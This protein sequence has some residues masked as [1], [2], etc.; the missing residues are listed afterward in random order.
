MKLTKIKTQIISFIIC[1]ATCIVI[2]PAADAARKNPLDFFKKEETVTA[3]VEATTE[4]TEETAKTEN[5]TETE[6]KE[7]KKAVYTQRDKIIDYAL[8]EVGYSQQNGY[9]KFSAEFGSGYMAWCNYFVVWC[10]KRAGV[11][12]QVITGTS[13]YDGNCLIY[14]NGLK[15]QGRFYA[16]DGRYT[17]KKGDLVFFNRSRSTSN[18]THIGFVLSADK[19]SVTTIEGNVNLNGRKSV[20]KITRPRN[21]YS[22][23]IIIIGFGVPAY[24]NEEVPKVTI[25]KQPDKVPV[26]SNSKRKKDLIDVKKFETNST[27]DERIKLTEAIRKAAETTD[28]ICKNIDFE[29]VVKISYYNNSELPCTSKI[30]MCKYS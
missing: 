29:S 8:S 14:M 10:A 4:K 23:S 2:F 6:K 27:V 30:C 19:D 17:P 12:P 16:D 9:N 26:K 11:S 22:G 7:T 20:V 13:S 5:K 28:T 15:K 1:A 24:D 25:K 3:E 18:A 21:A